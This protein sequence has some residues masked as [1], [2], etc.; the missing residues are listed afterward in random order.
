MLDFNKIKTFMLQGQ[1]VKIISSVS[2]SPSLEQCKQ[3]LSTPLPKA[4]TTTLGAIQLV[5]P[6]FTWDNR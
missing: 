3:G 5:L 2:E 4:A 1:K 6:Q